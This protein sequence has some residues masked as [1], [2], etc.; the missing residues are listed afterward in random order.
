MFD[1]KNTVN[2]EVLLT[3]ILLVAIDSLYLSQV[4]GFFGRQISDIQGSPLNVQLL[5][6]I[7]CYILLVAGIYYFIIKPRRSIRDA[8]ALG[9]VVYGVFET[10]NKALFS[11]WR[12]STVLIDTLWGGILFAIV[13]A[14]MRYVKL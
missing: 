8:F 13:A 4:K 2:F 7:I 11:K 6:A 5:P 9:I 1:F 12:W 10:T 3:A 14:I